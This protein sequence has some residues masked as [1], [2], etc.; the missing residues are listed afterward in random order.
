MERKQLPS[1]H[2]PITPHCAPCAARDEN[3]IPFFPSLNQIQIPPTSHIAIYEHPKMRLRCGQKNGSYYNKHSPH[4]NIKLRIFN[5]IRNPL[6]WKANSSSCNAH[7]IPFRT[8]KPYREQMSY[9]HT[10]FMA[11]AH[12]NFLNQYKDYSSY[13]IQDC[14]REMLD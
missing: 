14:D 13:P 10:L 11:S 5:I 2:R 1:V 12:L 9:H 4:S 3:I 6:R 7:Q 8:I